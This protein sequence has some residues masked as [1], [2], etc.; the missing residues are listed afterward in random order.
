M[1]SQIESKINKGGPYYANWAKLL[2]LTLFK[3]SEIAVMGDNAVEK[4]LL[5]QKHYLPASIFAGGKI[6]NLPILQDKNIEG[7]T[8]IFVCKDKT[9]RMPSED[10]SK[11]L[12]QIIQ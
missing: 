10:V 9:C 2:G 3:L 1:L 4:S 12:E 11:A 6:E 5:M 8:M 7:R